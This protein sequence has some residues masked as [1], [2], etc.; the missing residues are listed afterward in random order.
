MTKSDFNIKKK[1]RKNTVKKEVKMF[2]FENIK[3][4]LQILK[5]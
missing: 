1:E 2:K 4:A 3:W 5:K